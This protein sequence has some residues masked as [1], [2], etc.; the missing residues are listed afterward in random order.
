MALPRAERDSARQ[1]Y[2]D[3]VV[4]PQ[5]PEQER[6]AAWSQF[7]QSTTAS[8][9]ARAK[10][11]PGQPH[12]EHYNTVLS[13]DE[14]KNFGPWKDEHAPQDSG[15]D[16]DLR[17]AFKEGLKP[18]PDG[19][20]ADTYKKP[21]HPTFS[22]QSKYKDYGN[23]GKWEGDTF[24]PPEGAAALNEQRIAEQPARMTMTSRKG[25]GA[26]LEPA[27]LSL[28][29]PP[30]RSADWKEVV[31]SAPAQLALGVNEFTENFRKW[32]GEMIVQRGQEAADKLM[33]G[34]EMSDLARKYKQRDVEQMK[35]GMEMRARADKGI[36]Q[37]AIDA[38]LVTPQDL[39]T[40]Q[41][42]FVSLVKSTPPMALG[43][44]TM[45]VTKNPVATYM[46]MGGGGGMMQGASTYAEARA[47]GRT[48][49]Q[50]NVHGLVD[51]GLEIFGEALPVAAAFK[52]GT[53]WMGKLFTTMA[54]EAGEE[55]ATQFMQDLHKWATYDPTITWPEMVRNMQVAG[56][57]GAGGG[58][59]FGASAAVSDRLGRKPAAAPQPEQPPA[60]P[61]AGAPQA[62]PAQGAP[63]TP[64]PASPQPAAESTAPMAA[65]TILGTPE[66][67]AAAPTPAAPEP[68]QAAP[69]AS[70]TADLPSTVPTLPDAPGAGARA[71]EQVAANHAIDHA[72]QEQAR[73]LEISRLAEEARAARMGKAYDEEVAK[74]E[75]EAPAAPQQPSLASRP[76]EIARLV[77]DTPG[78]DIQHV[79][80][81]QAPAKAQRAAKLIAAAF[82][83][84]VVLVKADPTKFEGKMF[85][86][87]PSK[88]YVNVD[89]NRSIR[90]VTGHELLHTLKRTNQRVYANLMR[91]MRGALD[92]KRAG[93][94]YENYY[95]EG[96]PEA[97]D[98]RHIEEFAADIFGDLMDDPK[99]WLHVFHRSEKPLVKKLWDAVRMMLDVIRMKLRIG[100]RRTGYDTR[101][102]IK[103][104]EGVRRAAAQAYADWQGGKP[105]PSARA[106]SGM[107]MASKPY[108][109]APNSLMGFKRG[110]E[111]KGFDE[112]NYRHT[113]PVRVKLQNGETF[114]DEIKGLNQAHALE[115][116]R[117]N[118]EGAEVE[119][120]S[121]SSLESKPKEGAFRF[122]K[123]DRI[124]GTDAK[125]YQ[126]V[127]RK[128]DE[129]GKPAYRVRDL[130]NNSVSEIPEHVAEKELVYRG[131]QRKP[132]EKRAAVMAL[133][134]WKSQHALFSL[135]YKRRY[136]SAVADYERAKDKREFSKTPIGVLETFPEKLDHLKRA[137]G[138]RLFARGPLIGTISTIHEKGTGLH[139]SAEEGRQVIPA[140]VLANLD[141]HASDPLAVVI[142]PKDHPNAHRVW[143]ILGKLGHEFSSLV[144]DPQASYGGEKV[145]LIVS[146][147]PRSATAMEIARRQGRV[148]YEKGTSSGPVSQHRGVEVVPAGAKP[149]GTK[150]TGGPTAEK[151]VSET[152]PQDKLADALHPTGKS[153]D[154]KA[155]AAATSPRNELPEPTE[156]QK[157]AGNYPK[158]HARV[159][160]L[161]VSIENPEGSART[162]VKGN[163]Q[164]GVRKMTAH[165]GYIRGTEGA[166]GDHLDIFIKPGTPHDYEGPVFVADQTKGDTRRFDE[167]K[168][169][170]GWSTVEEAKSAYDENYQPSWK[171]LESVVRFDS[172]DSFKAWVEEG[173]LKK[174]AAGGAALQSRPA[175]SRRH[176]LS[177]KERA[178]LDFMKNE[179]DMG[180][181][182]STNITP[183]QKEEMSE[184]A[185]QSYLRVIEG[186]DD[187]DPAARALRQDAMRMTKESG[188]EL[189]GNDRPGHRF[190]PDL[191][192]GKDKESGDWVTPDGRFVIEPR[193]DG[194]LVKMDGQEIGWH[195]DHH[196]A[197]RE[198]IAYYMD[199]MMTGKVKSPADAMSV[200]NQYPEA[201]R[202]RVAQAWSKLAEFKSVFRFPSSNKKSFDGIL[203]DMGQAGV[204]A[205]IHD[206][207]GQFSKPHL[208]IEF[209]DGHHA[210]LVLNSMSKTM[211]LNASDLQQGSQMGPVLYQAALVYAKNNGRVLVPDPAGLT[212]VNS[213][214]RTEQM[215]SGALRLGT[216]QFM[217]PHP[218]QGLYG[219]IKEPKT[220]A[221]EESNIALMAITS[222]RGVFENIPDVQAMRYDFQN[223]RFEE[224]GEHV[225]KEQ[226]DAIAKEQDARNIGAGRSTIAR[227]IFTN[228][229]IT[230]PEGADMLIA[231]DVT[232]ALILGGDT[233]QSLALYSKPGEKPGLAKSAILATA[234]AGTILARPVGAA[235]DLTNTVADAAAKLVGK[236]IAYVTSR[237]YDRLVSAGSR[238][239]KNTEL[240]QSIAHGVV[241]DYGLPEPY[242][243]QRDTRDIDIQKHLRKSK[244]MIDK[245]GAL[246]DAESMVAYQWM[247]EKPSS[248]E[249]ARL[250][251]LLPAESKQALADMKQMIDELGREAVALGLMTKE[252]YDRNAMAYL[253]RSY[254]KYEIANPQ[255]VASSQRA[256][257]IR[258]EHFRGRGLRDD[259]AVSRLPGVA[260][261]D[262]YVRLELRDANPAG[263]LGRLKRVVYVPAG[264]PIS[265]GYNA[266][267]NDG[268]WEAR[269]FD[270]QGQVGMWRDF[271]RDERERMGEIRE[272]RYSFAR[273]MIGLVHDIETARFL[274]WVGETYSVADEAAVAEKGGTVADAV[275]KMTTLTTY[276]D[277]QWV[278]VP[279]T[280]AQG[281]RLYKYGALQSR[282]VPGHIWND[283]R[284]TINV[285]SAAAVWRLYDEL[286]RAWK[287]SK[288]ALSP[289]VHTNNVMSNFVFLDLAEVQ[290][291]HLISSLQTL[292]DA[293]RG[294]EVARAKLERYLDSGAELGT[295][296]LHELRKEVIQ[297]LLS[298]LQGEEN[299][300]V[301]QLSLI[302]GIQLAARGNFRQVW[303]GVAASKTAHLAAA[304]FKAMIAAYQLEDSV[305]RLAKWLKETEGGMSDRDAGKAARE[306]FL[307]Y[308]INAPWIAALRRGPFPFLSFTYRAVPLLAEGF[309]KKPW[310]LMKYFAAGY[311][312]NALAYAMLGLGKDDEKK[313]R[314]RMPEEKSGYTILG[315]PRLLRMP[316]ND[317]HGSPVFLDIRRW[318]PG[319]DIFDV[320][321]SQGA[322]PLP[323]W[324]S[325]GGY[326]ALAIELASNKSQFTGQAIWKE[327][328]TLGERVAKVIDHLFKFAAPNFPAPNPAGYALDAAVAERGMMQT[329]S[330]KS[331]QDA[332]TGATDAFGREKNLPQAIASAVGVKIAAYPED[333]LTRN[334]NSKKAHE[335]RDNDETTSRYKREYRLSNKG[336]AARELFEER[337]KKQ[338][339]KRQEINRRY[340]EKL[341][342]EPVKK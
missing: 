88:V 203:T 2:F 271:T 144:I 70:A 54:A 61:P 250:V 63:P 53:P 214:R 265:A 68:A 228:S 45:I 96:R 217:R 336:D 321:G 212:H 239:A 38:G 233:K 139:R 206:H 191:L 211:Y 100:E 37:N 241:A 277:D 5:V 309:A 17:G 269:F 319:G 207:T 198:A 200:A 79:P 62:A 253:H 48:P 142:P 280:M 279:G 294:E 315:V 157:K 230:D 126:V 7:S 97:G 259:V 133:E 69:A 297:P 76:A 301:S 52:K 26:K 150:G 51:A 65:S 15:V 23:P 9:D 149:E 75:A 238:A 3:Q 291:K 4:S 237:I 330:W 171:G 264:Q 109:K 1:Q 130:G 106:E 252:T 288:T 240:G 92:L 20:W 299:E 116:A 326:F 183:E 270:K 323:T 13:P 338:A 90:K 158:G 310:K 121:S 231:G 208:R 331:I 194:F 78:V 10:R 29:E 204:V 275:D 175:F 155:H 177:P 103:D 113:Q 140:D 156:A 184:I 6:D 303:A 324:L 257:A 322:I 284:A 135:P 292:I 325:F 60:P 232:P 87:D 215:L 285:K 192:F 132:E 186:M 14:E 46:V 283:I 278:Q 272:V 21:N 178:D 197:V 298:Q 71:T 41:E 151:I 134:R 187:E 290:H 125:P 199:Q 282:Y 124:V 81:D 50:A 218:D 99:F 341:G 169:L 249:E 225:S 173:N 255:A 273:T 122:N 36:A 147:T 220:Q 286:L 77:E 289:V 165:Y 16:Y 44:A 327:S 28:Q 159:A 195:R 182:W 185:N 117:R 95:A 287:I 72:E 145:N 91:A 66:E 328:D 260:K 295:P 84:E 108:E 256:K 12:D 340:G 296:A 300:L 129:K 27:D 274:K 170:L 245:I 313:E 196:L 209:F 329:Y 83:K 11:L 143:L 221:E 244:Q 307:D 153:L 266:W 82:G 34:A 32:Q 123:G 39:D 229:L 318:I 59:V 268:V 167:H 162:Y 181:D 33:K 8:L 312:M 161:D 163:G 98:T 308:R 201:V 94:K 56:L 80:M 251:R 49:E 342:L 224:A 226:L 42:A 267:R 234:K 172:V 30:Q 128:L 148:I 337:M 293:E 333:V 119:P 248:A 112:T 40:A 168:T 193:P 332:G 89:S 85:Q 35:A 281:T 146:A 216:T 102:F 137:D 115:R 227:A 246:D 210:D 334:L 236:P 247:Q 311:A 219:W 47:K 262:H 179:A 339:E 141:D 154:E 152:L 188:G 107:A 67:E 320:T 335:L 314:A 202:G 101:D 180:R 304:P 213:Y 86:D 316:W 261:G 18:G 235:L 174:R 131:D 31:K 105:A 138:T 118:W 258:A 120:I 243:D 164:I 305:F 104:I 24:V 73:D 276:S 205:A 55:V 22:D 302:Q 64:P 114:N 317:E 19:H 190:F 57:A 254:K 111:N 306:A 136:S 166:D 43:A 242:I 93:G 189:R 58:F 127:N 263:G 74:A 160:G 25:G 223:R 176:E 110:G 222:M